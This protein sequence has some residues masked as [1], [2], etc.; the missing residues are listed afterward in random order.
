MQRARGAAF[1][2]GLASALIGGPALAWGNAGHEVIALI[3]R[4]HLAAPVR[5]RVEQLLAE[6]RDTLTA[7]DLAPRAT[8]A[9]VWRRDHPETATWHYVN[10]ELDRPD[11]RRACRSRRSCVVDKI[12]D[13][14]SE[15]AN[16]AAPEARKIFA[17]KMILHLVGDLHQPLH[18]ADAHDRGGNCERVTFTPA[19]WSGLQTWPGEDTSLH[20]YWD[21]VGVSALGRSPREIAATLERQ[22]DRRDVMT[23]SAGTPADWAWETFAVGRDVAYRYGGPLSCVSGPATPLSRA[24][25]DQARRATGQQLSRAGIRLAVLLNRAF[26]HGG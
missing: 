5:R 8:W 14:A 11:L 4:D 13:F 24:Y 15:L 21:D 20:H 22:I 23:W 3:A 6:D 1:V 19:G 10:L 26:S 17:L 25:Q 18:A 2:A 16:P 12:D 7:P 9:D